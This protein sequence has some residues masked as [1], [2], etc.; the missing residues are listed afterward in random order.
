MSLVP[1]ILIGLVVFAGIVIWF[2][3]IAIHRN[4]RD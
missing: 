3:D 1:Y 2:D 4:T